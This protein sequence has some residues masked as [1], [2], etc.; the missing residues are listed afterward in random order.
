MTNI[1]IYHK[2]KRIFIYILLTIMAVITILPLLWMISTSLKTANDVM[3]FP[4]EIIPDP[5]Q[6][7]NYVEALTAAPFGLYFFNSAKITILTT[8]GLIIVSSLGGYGFARFDFPFKNVL[9][10]ILLSAMMVPAAMMLIPLYS[11]FRNL[12]W[13]DRHIAL[14]IPPMVANTFS[15]FLF[16]QFFMS[17][18]KEL[19]ESARID[20]CGTMGIYFRILMPLSKPIVATATVLSFMWNWNA[21]IRPLIFLNSVEKLTVTVGLSV[22]QGQFASYHHLSM[23]VATTALIPI[24]L[25]YLGAQKYIISGMITSGL[26]S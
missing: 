15:T 5:I 25:V 3:S 1:K 11:M 23:A 19:D 8:A 21:F 6:F 9:F 22:F 12:G 13:L 7:Y 2:L 24:F 16:R 17:L 10:G 4:P 14:I 20:G 18:P 26:K